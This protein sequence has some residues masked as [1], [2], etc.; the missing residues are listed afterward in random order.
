M[1]WAG[2]VNQTIIDEV[3]LNWTNYCDFMDKSF[4]ASYKF[5]SNSEVCIYA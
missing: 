5:Q 4:F 1:I 3:K 2:I